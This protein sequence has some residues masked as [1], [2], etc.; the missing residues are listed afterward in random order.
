MQRFV[1]PTKLEMA[2]AA[3]A[4]AAEL[5][6]AAIARKGQAA[7]IAATGAS[8]FEFLEI[9]TVTPGIDWARTVMFH[10]DEYVGMPD[11]HP[12][13]FRRYLQ[14]RLIDWVQPGTVHLIQGDAPPQA[15]CQRLN[16]LIAK[17]EIEVAF[18][19]IGE[20]G[21]LAFND[22]PAD[23]EV[24]DPYIIVE[25]DEACRRQQLGE[26]WFQ[27]L[28]EVPNQ[29][30][31]M[32]I[33][34]MMRSQA[35]VCTVPDKRKAQAVRDCFTGEVTPLHP[36]SILR[37]H[38]YACV[39]LDAEATSLLPASVSLPHHRSYQSSNSVQKQ[40]PKP[41]PNP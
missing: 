4:K 22:P 21:H 36:A 41:R 25:L 14:E 27:S 40:G 6:K 17:Y 3:A 12:A 39:F 31:S 9:L 2:E 11:S 19:G 32:S 23:F 24:E 33:K 28:A 35:I 30:I 10:L 18:V 7:F 38:E 13:S 29:A 37:Q 1:F 8:Q 15:E 5:L 26:G 16:D 20:N 34:Q